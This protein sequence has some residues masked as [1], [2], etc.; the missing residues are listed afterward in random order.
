ME[1]SRDS[2]KKEAVV[3]QVNEGELR[4]H[5]SEIVRENVEDT[6]NAMLEAEADNL[7]QARRYER[8]AER[9]STRQAL[10]A[11]LADNL[12][13]SEA[14]GSLCQTPVA[15]QRGNSTPKK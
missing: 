13:G 12:R 8:N 5:V 14:K 1:G 10:H 2:G 9:V 15:D 4:K 11:E 7:C 6:L 3:I